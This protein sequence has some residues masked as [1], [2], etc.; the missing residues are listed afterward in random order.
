MAFESAVQF[1]GIF[2]PFKL[3]RQVNHLRR[4]AW[5]CDGSAVSRLR[6]AHAAVVSGAYDLAVFAGNDSDFHGSSPSHC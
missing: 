5:A 2:D 4:L 6:L 1:T 3:P